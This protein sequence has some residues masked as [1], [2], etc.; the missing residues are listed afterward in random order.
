MIIGFRTDASLQ[1]GSG[2]VYRCL[3]LAD[4]L[5]AKGATC[6]F[7]CRPH[8]GNLMDFIAARGHSV[9]ALGAPEET[10]AGTDRQ[11]TW[12]GTEWQTDAGQTLAAM[13]NA[14]HDWLVVDHYALDARWEQMLRPACTHLM[15]IDDLA[16]RPHDCDL[17]LDQSLG[18]VPEDYAGLIPAGATAL[19]GPQYALLRPDFAALRPESLARRTE[20]VLRRLLVTLGGV[21]KDDLTTLMLDALDASTLPDDVTIGV[22]MGHHAPWLAHVRDRAAAMR[23]STEVL[24]GVSDMARLMTESDLAIGAGGSTTWERCALGLPSV[25]VVLADNQLSIA[26]TLEQAGC[27][28]SAYDKV[29][30][31]RE[32]CALLARDDLTQVLAQMSQ[33][34]AR[35]TD[36]TGA[37]RV[38]ERM[39]VSNA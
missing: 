30:C 6:V 25:T 2:H 19:L 37:D 34:A 23:R 16:D 12:L 8:D 7:F 22:V 18:R 14:H 36:G 24:V 35:I 9:I 27:T 4:A 38:V 11:D 3:T 26:E 20:P 29:E 32:I 17:L 31:G 33:S 15:V 28:I 1:I 13:A 10:Q 39:R 21:D 5:A